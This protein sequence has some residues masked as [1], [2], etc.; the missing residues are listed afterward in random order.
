MSVKSPWNAHTVLQFST[1]VPIFAAEMAI[2]SALPLS[3]NVESITETFTYMERHQ[4]NN[5]MVREGDFVVHL[6]H[7]SQEVL[8]DFCQTLYLQ[9]H[10][11]VMYSCFKIFVCDS[12]SM[13]IQLDN[14]LHPLTFAS[15]HRWH[16]YITYGWSITIYALTVSLAKNF[17]YQLLSDWL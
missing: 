17:T 1:P 9:L 8:K 3:Y 16:L 5:I 10:I 7:K 4:S 2:E 12:K 11:N 14:T 15:I 6:Q 13:L